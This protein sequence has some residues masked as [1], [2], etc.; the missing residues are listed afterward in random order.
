MSRTMRLWSG[1]GLLILGGAL[2]SGVQTLAAD[3][4]PLSDQLADLGRQALAQ[5]A[6]ETAQTFFKKALL[7][8]PKSAVA[9]RGMREIERSRP[10]WSGSRSRTPSRRAA[11]QPATPPQP[12]A[13]QPP[14]PK[15]TIE[16]SET[17]ENIARQQ[18]TNDVEQRLQ[19][20][21]NLLN[22]GQPEAALSHCS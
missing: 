7:L 14:Q 10:A 13:A 15:A 11:G 3:D 5:G 8:D 2:L 9:Q 1:A 20:A 16:Q 19:A 4:P 18:L 6:T 22:Q 17:A 21:R 12:P